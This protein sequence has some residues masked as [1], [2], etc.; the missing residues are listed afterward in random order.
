MALLLLFS[1][2]FIH[3]SFA[4]FNYYG[5]VIDVPAPEFSLKDLDGHDIQLKDFQGKYIYLMFGYLNCTKT[6][7]SQALVMDYLSNEVT[8]DDVHFIYVSMDPL[9]DDISKLKLYFKS[10]SHRLTILKGNNIRQMQAVA[11][12]FKAPFSIQ[13]SV[14][15]N[16]YEI[17]HPGYIFLI[18]PGGR[19]S[20]VYS[21][22]VIDPDRLYKDLS[23]YK[24]NYS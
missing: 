3:N 2:N 8:D 9:R 10:K 20:M 23:N 1:L 17:N 7:H 18:N 5:R 11:N 14:K 19:L 24:S 21:G 13:L 15:G 4:S 16:E 22:S 6:C 12:A